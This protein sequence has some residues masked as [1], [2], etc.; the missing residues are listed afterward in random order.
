[1]PDKDP[2]D[3]IRYRTAN[4]IARKRLLLLSLMAASTKSASVPNI[5]LS[6]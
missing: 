6:G 2:P 1:M 4:D 3:T 5:D